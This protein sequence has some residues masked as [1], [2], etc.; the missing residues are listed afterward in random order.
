VYVIAKFVDPAAKHWDPSTKKYVVGPLT[1]TTYYQFA[2][3][4][5]R[6][7]Q[8]SSASVQYA[9]KFLCGRMEHMDRT[10]LPGEGR[11]AVA[12]GDYH[13][14]INVHNPSKGEAAIRFRFSATLPSGKPGTISRFAEIK[15]DP[16][17]TISLDCAQVYELLQ[18]KPGF[19]DGFAVID[20]NVDQDVVA[21]Y[22]AAGEHGKVTTLQTERVQARNIQ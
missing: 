20:S 7:T 14:A 22:S 18:A 12:D 1:S 21:V 16:G 6:E 11:E 8:S 17:Q 4:R 15:L 2:G 10:E 13:T 3:I 19:I 5:H 9:A